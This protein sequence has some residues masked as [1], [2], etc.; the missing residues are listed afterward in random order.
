MFCNQ[1]FCETSVKVIS[2]LTICMK[3]EICE[4]QFSLFF[5]IL[6]EKIVNFS[7]ISREIAE[8]TW[9]GCKWEFMTYNWSDKWF[10]E[11]LEIA[12]KCEF[13]LIS[14]SLTHH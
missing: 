5:L 13:S 9:I 7:V 11:M 8:I 2:L 10:C 6:S 14:N 3:R 4:W 1:K 12:F